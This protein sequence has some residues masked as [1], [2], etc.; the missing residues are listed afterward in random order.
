MT[1]VDELFKRPAIPSQKRKFEAPKDPN[2]LY[3][4]VKLSQNGDIRTSL[5]ATTADEEEDDDT[6]AGPELP[7]DLE[8]PGSDEEGR[9]FGGGVDKDTRQ[10]MDFVD[11]RDQDE[12]VQKAEKID[13]G[14]LRKTA[15]S[16]EKKISK[17]AELRAKFEGQPQKFMASE[18][19]LDE[20]V[21][22]LSILS[23]HPE[24]YPEFA[25]LGC[26]ASLVSLLS[27]E[28]TDIAIDAM[29]I[30]DELTD[31][32]VSATQDQ[33]ETL[34]SALLD[35]DL[36]SILHSNLSRLNEGLESDRT[37]VYHTLGILESLASHPSHAGTISTHPSLLPWLL[38]R[39]LA[40]EKTTSQNKQYAAEILAILL[41]SSPAASIPRFLSLSGPD[42]YLQALAPYRKRDPPRGTEEEEFVENLFAGLTLCLS[43][44][45]GKAAFLEAEGV[46]LC[47]IM[48]RAGKLAR[49]RALR[50]LD[51]CLGGSGSGSGTGSSA[52]EGAATAACTRLVDA[53]GLKPLFAA[54]MHRATDRG[55]T[56]HIL[57]ILASMFR[58]LPPESAPRIRLLGKFV[59]KGYEKIA[60]LVAVRQEVAAR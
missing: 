53:A 28:N 36:L 11:L 49:P 22:A 3:K 57:G 45:G 58:R 41:Q 59:E 24:L 52:A 23:E 60:R 1:S 20:S 32:D 27:H 21:K 8:D 17:N 56:E 15:L 51:H 5:P 35:A 39:S 29:Q 16:F 37:G 25:R 48:V 12:G 55:A 4:S 10:M 13:A 50:L 30:I 14:W 31:E 19:D 38:A 34:V 26:L 33:W 2:E 40:P 54:F 42:A 47:L 43:T 6:A 7:P 44:S 9:F 18:A 46:E